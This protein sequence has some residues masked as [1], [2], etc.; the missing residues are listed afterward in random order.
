[1]HTKKYAK[2]KTHTIINKNIYQN[3]FNIFYKKQYIKIL[4]KNNI[5]K[6][7]KKLFMEG[8]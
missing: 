5:L 2:A 1:M 4:Y 8:R 3:Q 7:K 6:N